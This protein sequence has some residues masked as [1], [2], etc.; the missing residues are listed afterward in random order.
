MFALAS[1]AIGDSARETAAIF[2]AEL[3]VDGLELFGDGAGGDAALGGDARV[4]PAACDAVGDRAFGAG[5]LVGDRSVGADF[6]P[7]HGQRLIA[8]GQ[9]EAGRARG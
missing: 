7:D 6:Y 9:V 2:D 5:E 3:V 4:A 8:D 1:S